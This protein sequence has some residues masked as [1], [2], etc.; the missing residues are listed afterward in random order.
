[1]ERLLI[2]TLLA[3]C[4]IYVVQQ[5]AHFEPVEYERDIDD[6]EYEYDPFD[7]S[8]SNVAPDKEGEAPPTPK[9]HACRFASKKGGIYDIRPLSRNQKLLKAAST[10]S[11]NLDFLPAVDWVHEDETIANQT[12]YLNVCSDVHAVPDACK[13]L[14]KTD[15]APAF[16]VNAKGECFYLGA[17]C[18]R[19]HLCQR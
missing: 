6:N 8:T 19:M 13:A 3:C 14:Q 2:A 9:W 7:T 17:I 11:N 4:C 10:W 5:V 18:S 1:M 12:Y 16:D 15:P